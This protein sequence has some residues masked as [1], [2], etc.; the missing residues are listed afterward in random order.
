MV[1]TNDVDGTFLSLIDLDFPEAVS[2][3]REWHEEA[4][5]N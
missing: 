1:S 5:E 2:G 4:L 3:T